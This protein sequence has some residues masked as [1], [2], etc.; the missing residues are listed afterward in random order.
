MRSIRCNEVKITL[1]VYGKRKFFYQTTHCPRNGK[2][3]GKNT[4]KK[5]SLTT[6]FLPPIKNLRTMNINS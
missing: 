3:H 4:G 1:I 2:K 6:N 5:H